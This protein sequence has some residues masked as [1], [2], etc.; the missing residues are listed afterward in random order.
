VL[1]IFAFVALMLGA[2][3][4][5]EAQ[6]RNSFWT[7]SY[8]LYNAKSHKM[9]TQ[10]DISGEHKIN[11]H[12]K[13]FIWSLSSNTWSEGIV[14]MTY[15]PATWIELSIG[16]GVESDV[17]PLRMQASAFMAK[18]VHSLY[19][20][21]ELGGSGYWYLLEQ[22]NNVLTH[23]D[24]LNGINNIGLGVRAQ[25]FAGVGPRVQVVFSKKRVMLWAVPVAFDPEVKGSRNSVAALRLSF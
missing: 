14:G 20:A 7:E 21:T 18:G 12:L 9:S 23:S 13:V 15:V 11:E 19:L 25:R 10:V 8:N 5:V 1:R 22:N 16:G 6:S 4:N 3:C 2:V 24:T 17:N